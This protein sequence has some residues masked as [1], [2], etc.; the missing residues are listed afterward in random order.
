MATLEFKFS[1]DQQHQIQAIE[2]TCNLFAGQQFVKSQFGSFNPGRGMFD[3]WQAN[4]GHGN[5]VHVTPG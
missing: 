1:S 5:E 4:V 2:A 3:A